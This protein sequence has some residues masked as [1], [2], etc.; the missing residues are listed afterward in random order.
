MIIFKFSQ[1]ETKEAYHLFKDR[2]SLMYFLQDNYDNVHVCDGETLVT[3]ECDGMSMWGR[4]VEPT[5]HF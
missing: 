5:K 2:D 3:M 4:I 1:S